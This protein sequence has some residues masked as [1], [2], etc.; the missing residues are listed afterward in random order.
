MENPRNPHRRQQDNTEPEKRE[1]R[2]FAKFAPDGT[3]AAI[4][5]VANGAPDP[6]DG[7]D[8]T[9][10]DVTD[11]WPYDFSTVHVPPGQVKKSERAALKSE[12]TKH[13]FPRE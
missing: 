11:L 8:S 7:E 9:Y 13:A 2:H 4:V 3:V 1:F 5:E 10:V 6:E 12:L